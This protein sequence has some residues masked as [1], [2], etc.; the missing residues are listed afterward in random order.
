MMGDTECPAAEA[1]LRPV[2][3][4][5]YDPPSSNYAIFPGAGSGS[6]GSAVEEELYLAGQQVVWRSLGGGVVHASYG[7]SGTAEDGGAPFLQAVRARFPPV[8]GEPSDGCDSSGDDHA[9]PLPS[10]CALKSPELIVVFCP[11]GSC[12]EVPLPF[13]AQRIFPLREGLLVQWAADGGG[14]SGGGGGGGGGSGGGASSDSFADD[15]EPVLFTLAHPLDELKPIATA[16]FGEESRAAAAGKRDHSGVGFAVAAGSGAAEAAKTPSDGMDVEDEAPLPW[17]TDPVET[18]LHCHS[19]GPGPPLLLT[20]HQVLRRHAVWRL[21]A[22]PEPPHSLSPGSGGG[23]GGSGGDAGGGGVASAL[24]ADE[25][26]MGDGGDASFSRVLRLGD[27]SAV[28]GVSGVASPPPLPMLGLSTPRGPNGGG[29]G[30]MGSTGGIVAAAVGMRLSPADRNQ[31][32]AS[33]LG[34]TQPLGPG[35]SPSV[36]SMGGGVRYFGAD[37]TAAMMPDL[38]GAPAVSTL[39]GDAAAVAAA[40]GGGGNGAVAPPIWPELT[41]TLIW[42]EASEAPCPA[43]QVFAVAADGA[44]AAASADSGRIDRFLLCFVEP[45]E[46]RALCAVE[47]TISVDTRAA[48]RVTAKEA[49]R[50]ACRGAVGIYASG[51]RGGPPSGIHGGS[52]AGDVAGVDAAGFRRADSAAA[53]ATA[54]AAGAA[55]GAA[56][57]GAVAALPLEILLLTLDGRL[58]LHRGAPNAL[59]TAVSSP[60]PGGSVARA[61]ARMVRIGDAVFDRVNVWCA[62]APNDDDKDGGGGKGRD[63]HGG[64]KCGGASGK[65]EAQQAFR[66][67]VRIDVDCALTRAVLEACDSALSPAVTT[68]FRADVVRTARLLGSLPANGANGGDGG[69]GGGTSGSGAPIVRWT[70]GCGGDAEWRAFVNVLFALLYETAAASAAPP[71]GQSGH[72]TGDAGGGDDAWVT[73]LASLFHQTYSRDHAMMLAPFDAGALPPAAS[74]SFRSAAQLPLQQPVPA[75]AA[76]VARPLLSDPVRFV[77]SSGRV[78]DALHLAYEDLKTSQL[79]AGCGPKLASL[80]LGLAR[81][82][83]GNAMADF[84]DHYLR[85]VGRPLSGY[86]AADDGGNTGGG[87]G[88]NG[89]DG[90]LKQ[91]A[92]GAAAA[93]ADPPASLAADPP[94]SPGRTGF[95][96]VPCI[97]SWV[98]QRILTAAPP[99]RGNDGA[100]YDGSGPFPLLF[101]GSDDGSSRRGHVGDRTRQLCRFYEILCAPLLDDQ[102]GCGGCGSGGGASKAMDVDADA[103]GDTTPPNPPPPPPPPPAASA[104]EC[105]VLAMVEEGVGPAELAQMPF[106][107]ALP[108]LDMLHAAGVNAPPGWP[109][110]AYELV[111][112]EE[113]AALQ[114]MRDL[115]SD[116]VS[117]GSAGDDG[118]DGGGGGGRG[119][120]QVR[121]RQQRLLKDRRVSAPRQGIDSI[122][123]GAV[124]PP[125]TEGG[126]GTG[127]GSDGGAVS[128]AAANDISDPVYRAAI[129]ADGDGLRG[130]EALSSLRFGDD[131]RVREVCRMMRCTRPAVVRI[132]RDAG[133]A[134]AEYTHR[135]QIRLSQIG[136]RTLASMLGRGALTLGATAPLLADPLPIPPVCLSGRF[137]PGGAIVAFDPATITPP[138]QSNGWAFFHNGAAAGLRLSS[139]GLGRGRRGASGGAG[140]GFGGFGGGGRVSRTWILFNRPARQRSSA[141]GGML[142]ALG[143]QGHLSALAMT[144][145]YEYLTQGHDYTTVGLLLGMAASKAGTADHACSKTLCLHLPALLPAP[146]AEMDVSSVAQMAAL[147]GAGLLYRGMGHRL[148]TEFLLS[149]IG[150]P[151]EP[152]RVADHDGYVLAA[153]LALGFVNL[154]RGRR[155]SGGGGHGGGS[156]GQGGGRDGMGLAGL[157]DLH[158]EQRLHRYVVGGNAKGDRGPNSGG[159]AGGIGDGD[160][161]S[162][163]VSAADRVDTNVTGP[164][165][166]LALGLIYLKSNDAAVAARLALPASHYELDAVRPD[167]LMLRVIGRALILWDGVVPTDAWVD[168]QLPQLFVEALAAVAAVGYRHLLLLSSGLPPPQCPLSAAAAAARE[169]DRQSIR[170][171]HAYVV[172]GA[173]FALGLRFAGT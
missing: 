101:G 164:A 46:A 163:R 73:L 16:A 69:S 7:A 34:L 118:D 23:D 67:R 58:E 141:H 126:G 145:T 107:L 152:D 82:C 143:L 72:G 39:N 49:F 54:A 155:G 131:L 6:G 103:A 48:C 159:I 140:G 35:S 106:G 97:Y 172:A 161:R 78:F 100:A 10:I 135:Q 84:V 94:A 51:C 28:L 64:H 119:H 150:R 15:R 134:D 85:D 120:R 32:L 99:S 144:D 98:L 130:I 76:V 56:A 53:A 166:V 87:G 81:R 29:G 128:S 115:W 13:Q 171:A 109:V 133:M 33:A 40:D 146:F 136:R 3:L 43:R 121:L 66:I 52:A 18:V 173:C 108:L 157:A 139:R 14:G 104:L 22:A 31:A 149:E 17:M 158:I 65:G 122:I 156:S 19:D 44:E 137:Y 127:A 138:P 148:M 37:G 30:A 4:G 63:K 42:R 50:V 25:S 102:A 2:V 162:D 129:A 61:A 125:L 11:Q 153:G 71:A 8:E 60:I 80:L 114:R 62:T 55:A 105:L 20:Y 132:R 110:A 111:G 116:P 151:F 167:L 45:D 79:A 91:E 142:M 117:I 113:L 70:E 83:P 124:G 74:A 1:A 154:G 59:I 160:T 123:D 5:A 93:A 112:R 169:V 36:L 21:D 47:I 75:S 9:A 24:G 57:V 38:L 77:A 147:A 68:A 96:A 165:A 170:Q 92:R 88:N 27:V 26:S 12:Y 86:I 90:G 89:G 95:A 41:M 168:E